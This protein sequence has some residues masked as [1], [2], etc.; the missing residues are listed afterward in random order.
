MRPYQWQQAGSD[1]EGW[2]FGVSNGVNDSYLQMDFTSGTN[3]NLLTGVTFTAASTVQNTISGDLDAMYT[4]H[5]QGS[6]DLY[7][8]ERENEIG[9]GSISQVSPAL[10]GRYNDC[11]VSRLS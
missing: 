11:P 7:L 8:Y 3:E 2:L 4:V 9:H 6:K 1:Q 5:R 10:S